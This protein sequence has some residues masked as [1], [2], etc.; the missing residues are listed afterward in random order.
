MLPCA[1][2]FYRRVY[3]PGELQSI[4]TSTLAAWHFSFL[5]CFWSDALSSSYKGLSSGHRRLR[6]AGFC[7][8]WGNDCLEAEVVDLL[9]RYVDFGVT[10]GCRGIHRGYN[11]FNCQRV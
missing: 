8:D 2:P 4:T 11:P 1:L 3:S 6:E 5:V 9:E 10:A 7:A